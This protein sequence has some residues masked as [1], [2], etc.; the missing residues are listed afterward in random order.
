LDYYNRTT[1]RVVFYAPVA[2]G[3][4]T[5]ELLGNNGTV[6]NSGFEFSIGWS[7]KV[8]SDF[9]YNVGINATTISNK[10]VSLNGAREFIPGAQVRSEYTTRTQVGYPIG[11]FWGYKVEGVYANAAEAVNDPLNASGAWSGYFKYA[12][13]NGDDKRGDGDQTYLGSPIPKLLLGVDFGF[14]WKKLDFSLT[15]QGQFGNKILNAKRMNRDLFPDGNYDLDFY[16]N[17]WRADATSDTYPSPE[18]L[19]SSLTLTTNSFFVEDGSYFRI[20]NIQVGY[21][22]GGMKWANS[23]RVYVAAQRPFTYFTYN[24]FSPEVSGSPIATGIDSST[25]PM[26]SIYT[27]G[28]RLNF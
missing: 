27:V 8:G 22:F 14:T 12:N 25:Y 15:L 3:G 21:T 10:V 17:A 9:S 23:I 24:G 19:N 26:Q 16:K 1:R 11:A 2:A 20:Q 6:R 28:L 13:T 7:D 4:G 18:A 5:A